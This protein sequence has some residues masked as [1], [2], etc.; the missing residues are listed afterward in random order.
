M[1]D[2]ENGKLKTNLY[3]IDLD[4]HYPLQSTFQRLLELSGESLT[5]SVASRE[6]QMVTNLGNF[7][8]L[9][10]DNTAPYTLNRSYSLFKQVSFSS[11]LLLALNYDGSI[12]VHDSY[13]QFMGILKLNKE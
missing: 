4:T 11:T 10:F 1:L 2:N 5:A 7:A 13:F 8:L 3:T 9:A 6:H 12:S